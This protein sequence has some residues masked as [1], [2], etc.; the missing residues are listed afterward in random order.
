VPE[1]E[2]FRPTTAWI[3]LDAV[4]HNVA[5]FVEHVA[6]SAVCAVVKADGYGHGA[7]ECARAAV[8]GGATMLAVALV[9]EGVTLRE[10]EI[11]TPI[12]VLS[13]F[14]LGA[15]VAVVEY[16]LTPTVYSFDRIGALHAVVTK[17][18][19]AVHLKIDTGMN[20]VGAQPGEALAL[21][22]AIDASTVLRLGGTFTHL[23]V[24]DTVDWNHPNHPYTYEQLETFD[25]VLAQLVADGI[26][27]GVC[28]AANSA[29]ALAHPRARYDMVRLGVSMYGSDPDVGC[30]ADTFGVA[31]RAPMHLISRVSHV[32]AASAGDRVSYGL[33][34]TLQ[35]DSVLAI[36]P[37]GY[38]D[39]VPRRLSAVGGEVLINGQRFPIAGRVTMDQ[40]VVDCGPVDG[41]GAVVARNDEV[42][43]LGTQGSQT[44]TPWDWAVK[45]DTIAYEITC[46]ISKRVPR[47]FIDV[48]G[49][50]ASTTK[51]KGSKKGM[52]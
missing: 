17:P 42:V 49:S 44:I 11:D 7:I 13:E 33:T 5:A 19:L 10:A 20:R 47:R 41:P 32:K 36:V 4:R 43:L 29:G 23:A 22:R 18:E 28:H 31:L 3:D 39:G 27:P 9:E 1:H 38:A 14:P 37:I 21:A 48:P 2:Q 15:E 24:A 16:N 25:N 40:I 50:E 51:A 8:D 26:D 45:L 46:G 6:P 52:N 35:T 30:V 34:Y 12:L